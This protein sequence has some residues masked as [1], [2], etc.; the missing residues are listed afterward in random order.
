MG[1]I[2]ALPWCIKPLFGFIF[3]QIMK[4]LKK[5][6]YLVMIGSFLWIAIYLFISK[7][8]VNI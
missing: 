5:T 6:K 8:D 7:N 1:G 3:D 4:K 2:L